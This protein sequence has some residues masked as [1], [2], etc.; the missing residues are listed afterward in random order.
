MKKK[1]IKKESTKFKKFYGAFKKNLELK[2]E[3]RISQKEFEKE[4]K[5]TSKKVENSLKKINKINPDKYNVYEN[6]DK[7]FKQSLDILENCKESCENKDFITAIDSVD[8]L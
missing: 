2:L 4:F 8:F 6:I 3:Q 1:K 5:K 7:I